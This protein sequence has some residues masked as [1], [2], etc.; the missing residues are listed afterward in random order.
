MSTV[1]AELTT[2]PD[3]NDAKTAPLQATQTSLPPP[4]ERL[5]RRMASRRRRSRSAASD[6]RSS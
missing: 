6:V 1:R 4:N 3:V 2:A 5:P